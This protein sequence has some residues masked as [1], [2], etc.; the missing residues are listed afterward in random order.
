VWIGVICLVSI[1]FESFQ[2]HSHWDKIGWIPF[3]SWPVKPLDVL[4]NVLLYMPLGFLA[5]KATTT[6]ATKTRRHEVEIVRAYLRVGIEA[7]VLSLSMEVIQDFS[8]SR[9]PSAT[10]LVCNVAGALLGLACSV[11]W[12]R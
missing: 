12:V 4:G 3:Y 7:F 5:T 11:R 6:L 10:D 2:T 8:H 1:P 9:F